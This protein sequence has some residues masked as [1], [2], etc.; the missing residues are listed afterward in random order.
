MSV[1][2]TERGWA[3]HCC[4]AR[5]CLFRRNT[6]LQK[7]NVFV[8]VSTVGNWIPKN[9]TKV[10]EIGAGRFFETM[11]FLSKESDQEYHDI[12]V[13]KQIY[14]DANCVVLK[15]A[16]DNE[17]NDMHEAVVDEITDRLINDTLIYYND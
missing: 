10:E 15:P 5:D 8:V 7:D 2:R 3:G 4:V 9:A 14:F 16:I 12:D 13:S 1:I 6:L 17:A 11:V